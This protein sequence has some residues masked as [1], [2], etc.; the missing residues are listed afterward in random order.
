M[1]DDEEA[2]GLV[3]EALELNQ[4]SMDEFCL[5]VLRGCFLLLCRVTQP[6]L[7]LG[8][9]KEALSLLKVCYPQKQWWHH[10]KMVFFYMFH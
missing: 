5:K 9:V 10:H 8:A 3:R 7:V 6:L 4:L 1:Y 2:D